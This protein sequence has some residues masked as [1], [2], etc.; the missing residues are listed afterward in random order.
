MLPTAA[1]LE[2]ARRQSAWFQEHPEDRPP[3]PIP[4]T[5]G[6]AAPAPDLSAFRDP[7]WP[8]RWAEI[9]LVILALATLVE[10]VFDV[11]HLSILSRDL[12][13]PGN[14]QAYFDSNDRLDAVGIAMAL[15]WLVCVITF[16]AWMRRAY[17]NL[18]AI[19]AVQR[20]KP[21]WAVGGWFV[22]FLNLWRPKQIVNDI[23]R[24]GDPQAPPTLAP[25]RYTELRVPW[26]ITAWWLLFIVGNAAGRLL[27]R[28]STGTVAGERLYTQRDLA[29]GV[30][31]ILALLLAFVV[32]RSLTRRQQARAR[33]LAAAPD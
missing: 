27:L 28:T 15:G 5:R 14:A 23:W 3:D 25:S 33:A 13:D 21:G 26:T 24:T 7:E 30:L 16:I 1:A 10:V 22:P 31:D 4:Q 19:G 9:G 29:G 12:S 20:F 6:P 17:R 18:P 11:W 2:A 32:V 8:G